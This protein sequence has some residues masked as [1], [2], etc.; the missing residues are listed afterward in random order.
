MV[1]G[2]IGTTVP[3]IPAMWFDAAD[4]G[5]LGDGKADDAPA[6]QRALDHAGSQGGGVV[7]LSQPKVHYRLT[8]GLKLPS[9]VTL[10]GPAPVHYPYNA[11]NKGACALVAEFAEHREWII[12]AAT[13]EHGLSFAY[14]KLVGRSLPQGVTYNCGVK[15]VLLTSKGAVPFGGIRMHGCPGSFVEGVCIDRVGCGLLVNYTFCGSYN[16]VVNTLYYGVAAWD[17]ANANIFTV[18]CMHAPPWPTR[19]PVE[20]QLPFMT[21]M[22]EHFDTTLNLSTKDHYDR[23]YG[24]LCGSIASTSIGNVL[25]AT[26]EQFPGGMFLYNA[27]STDIRQCYLEGNPDKMVC[28]LA[29]SRSRFSVQAFHAYLSGTGA[30]FDFGI[31]VLGKI[32]GSGILYAATFGKPPRDDGASLLILEGIQ[33]SMP[34]APMQRGIRYMTNEMSWNTLVLR[35]SWRAAEDEAPAVRFDPWSQRVEFKGAVKGAGDSIVF[36]LP[37]QC[38]PS[39][40]RHYKVPG[41]EVS[42]HP[43][44]TARVLAERA[45][46][47]LD[48]ISFAR[49]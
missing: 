30:V 22:K 17:D 10:E 15:N 20:Y 40:L 19:V 23:P 16:L 26:V 46:V 34:G 44:G 45:S 29:A 38:R 7:F 35:S 18:H 27:Y 8:K 24:I 13:T 31:E 47:S 6:I 39:G 28:G 1:G 37:P 12:E 14:N 48:G 11:G 36:M 21:Q 42:I 25:D 43:D 32:F 9:Y 49:W 4:F 3:Y 2:S 33:P 5:V 41:G